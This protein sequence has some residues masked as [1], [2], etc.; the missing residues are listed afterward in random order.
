MSVEC[1]VRS[2]VAGVEVVEFGSAEV[3]VALDENVGVAEG[4]VEVGDAYYDDGDLA[5]GQPPAVAGHAPAASGLL[6]AGPERMG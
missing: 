6:A 1:G 4:V 3:A 2:D 5:L